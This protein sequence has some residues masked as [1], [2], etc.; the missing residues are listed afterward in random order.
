[1]RSWAEDMMMSDAVAKLVDA[2]EAREM[3]YRRML[4]HGRTPEDVAAQIMADDFD[5]QILDEIYGRLKKPEPA[6]RFTFDVYALPRRIPGLRTWVRL[7]GLN[8]EAR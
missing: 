5:E 6:P 4:E 2:E 1:M 8:Q 7:A 3:R